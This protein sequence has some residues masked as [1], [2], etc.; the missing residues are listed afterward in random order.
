MRKKEEIENLVEKL[1]DYIEFIEPEDDE[2]SEDDL[3]LVAAAGATPSYEHFLK[4]M[5]EK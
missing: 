5:K 2:L 4:K 3:D 1:A